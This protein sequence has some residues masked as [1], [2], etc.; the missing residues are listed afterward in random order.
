MTPKD[1]FQPWCPWCKAPIS[2]YK[3]LTFYKK[4]KCGNCKKHYFAVPE[5]ETYSFSFKA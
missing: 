5:I 1:K 3:K 2:N 4:Y